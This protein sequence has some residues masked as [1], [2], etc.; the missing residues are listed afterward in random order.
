MVMDEHPAI[1]VEN[2]SVTRFMDHVIREDCFQ[3]Y[4]NNEFLT[5][6][7]ASA[8]N[9]REL[10]A[11]FV[12]SEGLADHV[13][14]VA[15]RGSEIWIEADVQ[16][17]IELEYRSSGGCGIK[18]IPKRVT[19]SLTT[20]PEEVFRI[21]DA[22]E[23]ETWKKTGG[24]HCSVL[25]SKGKQL[26]QI[27]DIGRHNTVDKVIGF[28]E[29]AGIDRSQC[30]IGCTGRQPGGMVSKDANAGIPIVISR[31]ASTNRGILTA[32]QTGITL[33]CFSRRG[34]FTIYAN[35]QRIEGI[36]GRTGGER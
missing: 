12:I 22:I 17:P 24:V 19:S 5:E 36:L 13:D 33:I 9:L 14:S 18:R 8:E 35:P 27:C 26:A 29:L 2:G 15:V 16:G 21:T 4:L 11:G 20:T 32:E 34:R 28:A 6:Q 10:G 1:R 7:I 30:C 3:F 23:S 25:F 31:A